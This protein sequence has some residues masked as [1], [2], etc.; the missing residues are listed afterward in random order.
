MPESALDETQDY[1]KLSGAQQINRHLAFGCSLI[2]SRSDV[3]YDGLKKPRWHVDKLLISLTSLPF[4][5]ATV[6]KK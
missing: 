6:H 5:F 4:S 2:P 3:V 1:R